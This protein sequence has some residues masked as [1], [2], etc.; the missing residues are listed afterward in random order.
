MVR[1]FV[2]S[3]PARHG[4]PALHATYVT[5]ARGDTLSGI[6]AAHG[7]SWPRLWAG[8]R[9][10]L[11]SDPD[12]ITP[13]QVL[14]IAH[15]PAYAAFPGSPAPASSSPPAQQPETPDVRT[16]TAPPASSQPVSGSPITPGSSFEQCVISR[17]SGGNAQVMNSSQHYGLYQFSASTWAAYGGNPGDFGHASPAQQQQVFRTAMSHPGG[18]SNWSPYDGCPAP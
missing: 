8:N 3:L 2:Q 5:V 1:H 6:A 16:V 17:E 15:L 13:G 12:A 4:Q 9:S 7:V 14:R 11:G 18:A 10:V